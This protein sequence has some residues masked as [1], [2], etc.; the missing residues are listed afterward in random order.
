[1]EHTPN[2]H[3]QL[4]S[5]IP[6]FVQ[7]VACALEIQVRH[8]QQSGASDRNED[9][10]ASRPP[11]FLINQHIQQFVI[12]QVEKLLHELLSKTDPTTPS[13]V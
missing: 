13:P 4:I 3:N 5:R 10:E 11:S 1:M 12:T 7:V 9:N 8:G 2:N 6:L